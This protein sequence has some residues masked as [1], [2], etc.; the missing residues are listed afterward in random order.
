MSVNNKVEAVGDILVEQV[1]R[2]RQYS[3]YDVFVHLMMHLEL[4]V[5]N[6]ILYYSPAPNSRGAY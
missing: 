4:G 2:L 5:L 3:L 6:I 1:P